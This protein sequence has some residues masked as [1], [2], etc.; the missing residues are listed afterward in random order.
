M[1][2]KSENIDGFFKKR[3]ENH[4]DNPGSVVWDNIS[5]KLGHKKK[6]TLV[7]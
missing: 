5:E 3:L 7:L 1:N 6:R 4:E 2:V